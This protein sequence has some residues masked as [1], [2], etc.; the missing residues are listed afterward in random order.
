MTTSPERRRAPRRRVDRPIKLVCP[1]TGRY[2]LAQAVDFSN[3]G[4]AF[5][6]DHATAIRPGDQIE[7]HPG[8]A[9]EGALLRRADFRKARVVRSLA[10]GERTYYAVQYEAAAP[11]DTPLSRE[12]RAA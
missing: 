11:G 3:T 10:R 6:I 8:G 9:T 7:L 2:L 12:A 1:R 4:A 5:Q